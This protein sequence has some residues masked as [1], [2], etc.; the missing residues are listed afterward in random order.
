MNNIQVTVF[1]DLISMNNCLD[2]HSEQRM[3]R[4]GTPVR[5][6]GQRQY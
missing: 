4:K 5:L 1:V 3:Q 6:P 2:V